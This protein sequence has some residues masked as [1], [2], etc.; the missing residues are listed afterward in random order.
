MN[1]P[2]K[3]RKKVISMAGMEEPFV[4]NF[5]NTVAAA[6]QNSASNRNITPLCMLNRQ[7]TKEGIFRQENPYN[8]TQKK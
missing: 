4:M 6:K 7:N 2:M 1:T 5:T 8:D 3:N